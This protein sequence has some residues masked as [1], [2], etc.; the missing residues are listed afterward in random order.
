VLFVIDSG[1]IIGLQGPRSSFTR[2]L[3]ATY[4]HTKGLR[5]T[6][7][8]VRIDGRHLDIRNLTIDE[9]DGRLLLQAASLH[10]TYAIAGTSFLLQN[11][12]L[13]TPHIVVRRAQ[14]G[15]FDIARLFA[16]NPSAT[17]GARPRPETS[18][19]LAVRIHDGYVNF[20]NRFAPA[21]TGKAF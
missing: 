10:I 7:A 8:D 15:S 21:R 12:I 19:H 14:D 16:G 3:L 1:V 9:L 2:V 6:H 5:L 11:V 4:L 13:E 18:L 20:I 17:T